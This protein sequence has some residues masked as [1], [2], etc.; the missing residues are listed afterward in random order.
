[1]T[2]TILGGSLFIVIAS[3]APKP[4]SSYYGPYIR[5]IPSRTGPRFVCYCAVGQKPKLLANPHA[6][7]LPLKD[8]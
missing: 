7:G 8:L 5:P 4:Y 2:D 1:M 3:W 6:G